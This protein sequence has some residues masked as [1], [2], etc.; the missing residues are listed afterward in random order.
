MINNDWNEVSISTVS[1]S[2]LLFPTSLLHLSS[3]FLFF[4]SHVFFFLLTASSGTDDILSEDLVGWRLYDLISLS[5][6]EDGLLF[7]CSGHSANFF[8]PE[9]IIILIRNNEI[10]IFIV[11]LIFVS[12][13]FMTSLIASSSLSFLLSLYFPFTLSSSITTVFFSFPL[14]LPLSPFIGLPF[15]LF[16]FPLYLSFS[17]SI[18]IP[19]SVP[20]SL[21]LSLS[22]S[23]S[24]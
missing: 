20:L 1:V 3:S 11:I 7:P 9:V 23:L 12:S 2:F 14:S 21:F 16:L 15:S 17:F 4:P 13:L 6:F 5:F 24:S 18:S 8:H 22:L 19:F 10:I